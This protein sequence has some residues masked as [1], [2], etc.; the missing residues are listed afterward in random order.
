MQLITT[1][2]DM[3]VDP[4]PQMSIR[5]PSRGGNSGRFGDSQLST[6]CT[7]LFRAVQA[8]D[9]EVI[10]LLLARGADPNIGAMGY[11]PFLVAA[12]VGPGGRGGAG[13]AG[14]MNRDLPDLLIQHGASVNAQISD[15]IY[16]HYP[17][18]QAPP[19]REGTSA[20]HDAVQRNSL[21]LVKYL[22]DHGADPNLVDQ[23]GRKP[24]DLIGAGAA[25]APGAPKGK[26]APAAKG[27]GKGPA[28]AGGSSNNEIRALLEAA[29]KK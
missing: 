15:T 27:K 6:G 23:Q 11:T 1:L 17:R 26:E 9:R 13:A 8:N 12:G 7:P 21:D 28:P 22:L 4:N 3:G 5:R 18:Y 2:L 24:I 19:R 16:T 10:N 29:M 20:L 25:A 14:P